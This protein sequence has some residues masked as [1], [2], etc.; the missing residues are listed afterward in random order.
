MHTWLWKTI[1]TLFLFHDTL[2]D[3]MGFLQDLN[4]KEQCSRL[5]VGIWECP[6]FLFLVMGIII[7]VSMLGTNLI[8]N[9]Y[10]EPEIATLVVMIVTAILFVISHVM[11][12]SFERMA[13]ATHART[14]FISIISHQLRNPLSSIRWQLEVLLRDQSLEERVHTY[15]E[16]ID[17]Y[18]GRLAKLVNDLLTVTRIESNRLVLTPAP[19]S[20]TELTEKIIGDNTLFASASNISF[21]LQVQSNVPLAYADESHV[22]WAVENL[23]NNAVRYSN[24][25]TTITIIIAKKVPFIVW[26]IVNQGIPIPLDDAH[27]IFKKFFRSEP[28]SRQRVDGSGLGLFIAKSVVEASGGAIGFASDKTGKTEFWLTLPRSTGRNNKAKTV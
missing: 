27:H 13:Q 14:E 24:P 3:V 23:I 25:R 11:I 4:I 21:N 1:C 8:A 6:H 18:A 19:F 20:L 17:E 15:L 26:R 7:V 9:R 10:T 16:G 2:H 28:S 5:K 12:K 22:R